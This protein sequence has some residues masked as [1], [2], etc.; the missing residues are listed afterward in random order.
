MEIEELSREEEETQEFKV[1]PKETLES[2]ESKRQNRIKYGLTGVIINGKE[3]G[4]RSFK[5]YYKQYL[6]RKIEPAARE[7]LALTAGE[8]I[9][10]NMGYKKPEFNKLSLYSNPR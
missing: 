4:Y 2:L 8:Q 7:Q 1:I 6:V 10:Q 3:V 5:Q 9:K